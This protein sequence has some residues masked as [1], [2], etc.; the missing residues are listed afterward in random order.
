[1]IWLYNAAYS[2]NDHKDLQHI[3]KQLCPHD[4]EFREWLKPVHYSARESDENDADAVT[5]LEKDEHNVNKQ[6]SKVTSSNIVDKQKKIKASK[7]PTRG[8]KGTASKEATTY[9]TVGTH[10]RNACS[11][12]SGITVIT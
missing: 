12:F 10:I 8:K 3:I 4:E 1:M 2:L 7:I 5:S 6:Q 11:Y 9:T